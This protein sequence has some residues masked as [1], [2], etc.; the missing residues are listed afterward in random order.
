MA[1]Y[2]LHPRVLEVATTTGTG[3]FTLADTV[4]TG[5]VRFSDIPSIANSD[6]VPYYAYDTAASPVTWEEGFGTYNLT[7]KTLA[8]TKILSNSSGTTSA[9]NFANAPNVILAQ[10]VNMARNGP[11]QLRTGRFYVTPSSIESGSTTGRVLFTPFYVPNPIS[12]A[13]LSIRFGATVNS[14]T[15]Y[16]GI[17]TDDEG[18]PGT[19]LGQANQSVSS[20]NANSTVTLSLS[21]FL[22]PGLYWVVS[23]LGSSANAFVFRGASGGGIYGFNALPIYSGS[24]AATTAIDNRSVLGYESSDATNTTL[25]ST[26]TGL[27][28]NAGSYSPPVVALGF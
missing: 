24:A 5:Y 9:I 27:A 19:L 16:L 8:R 12:L 21:L 25:P 6:L 17:A 14:S 7:A 2:K 1:V 28:V 18:Q 23:S 13:T 10:T 22:V 20:A 11:Y 3:T 26:F 4:Q 15:L